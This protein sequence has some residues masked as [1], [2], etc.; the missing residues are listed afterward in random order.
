MEAFKIKCSF[1]LKNQDK[2]EIAKLHNRRAMLLRYMLHVM[3][4]KKPKKFRLEPVRRAC[5]CLPT[6]L[7]HIC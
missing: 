2:M 7:D 4:V 5:Q 6:Q 3:P 1:S